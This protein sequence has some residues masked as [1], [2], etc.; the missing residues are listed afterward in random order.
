MHLTG[1]SFSS[2]KVLKPK[3]LTTWFRF[4]HMVLSLPLGA[5][6]PF[7]VWSAESGRV[8]DRAQCNN[9]Q[10][11]PVNKN[12]NPP[13]K[14]FWAFWA[15]RTQCFLRRDLSLHHQSH[16]RQGNHP[17]SRIIVLNRKWLR[18]STHKTVPAGVHLW[19]RCN[20]AWTDG[21]P[22]QVLAWLADQFAGNS[23]NRLAGTNH[24][25]L[26]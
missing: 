12:K 18:L 3:T 2:G 6:S 25:A 11:Q 1:R 21:L 4:K 26:L 10:I 13:S 22:V 19:W 5:H 15:T 9:N 16:N 14:Y 24:P 17:A 8:L 20:W 7:V 23:C